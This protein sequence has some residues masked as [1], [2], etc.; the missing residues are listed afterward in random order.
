M[1]I[2][3]WFCGF[4]GSSVKSNVTVGNGADAEIVAMLEEQGRITLER[5]FPFITP[6]SLLDIDPDS[7]IFAAAFVD[8]DIPIA[9][10]GKG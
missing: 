6:P 7:S 3:N 10:G 5:K 8:C 4:G 9:A 1:G 2:W